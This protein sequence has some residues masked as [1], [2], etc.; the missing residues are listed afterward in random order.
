MNTNCLTNINIYKTHSKSL[1]GHWQQSVEDNISVVLKEIIYMKITT[2]GVKILVCNPKF[3][4]RVTNQ[5]QSFK[6]QV[7]IN[8]H[9]IRVNNKRTRHLKNMVRHFLEYYMINLLRLNPEK[10]YF[11]LS[12][13]HSEKWIYLAVIS[14]KVSIRYIGLRSVNF[15]LCRLAAK[16]LYLNS[17]ELSSSNIQ[18]K[19]ISPN[20][21]EVE[22]IIQST[23]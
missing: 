10:K 12:P 3:E 16:S 22:I 21:L 19:T 8:V 14:R 11:L 15:W 2:A 20:K 5:F 23:T 17:L 9:I 1:S 6:G 13:K 18:G 4:V 7:S